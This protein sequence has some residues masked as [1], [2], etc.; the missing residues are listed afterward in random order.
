M[1]KVRIRNVAKSFGA[2]EVLHGI[3]CEIEDGEFVVIVGPSGCGKSTMLRLIAGLETLTSGDIWIGERVVNR[4]EPKERNV[5]M[6][7]Q[8]YA[9]YPHMTVF[10]N[11]AYSLRIARRPKSEIAERV[12]E[13][14]R[15]LGLEELLHRRPAQLSGGQRQRVAMGR[16]MIRQ[17]EVFLFDEPLSNLDAQLRGQMRVEIKHLHQRLRATSIFVTHDQIEAMTMADRLIVMNDGVIEQIGVSKMVYDRPASTF[18]AGFI[19]AP[20]MNF[21]PGQLHANGR[22]IALSNGLAL[23]LMSDAY[24]SHGGRQV[25]V[26]IRPE[27]IRVGGREGGAQ[28]AARLDLVEELGAGQLLYTSIDG[29]R[30][31]VSV[32]ADTE[33]EPS[34]QVSLSILPHRVHLFD[35]QSGLRLPSPG[36]TFD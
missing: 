14:A 15:I 16:A 25:T 31:V 26:G 3:S 23:D 2:V 13:V 7:F 8:S 19:G 35:P 32:P 36:A 18:V 9:L 5:A 20:S 6:V 27:H 29:H 28:F 22:T 17:P 11:L 12:N 33:W 21:V 30:F 10:K 24:A 1:A 4:L 34:E